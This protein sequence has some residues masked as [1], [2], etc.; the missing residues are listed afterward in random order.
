MLIIHDRVTLNWI[1]VYCKLG[2][3]LGIK[4]INNKISSAFTNHATELNGKLPLP[5]S[6]GLFEHIIQVF[7]LPA[8]FLTIYDTGLATYTSTVLPRGKVDGKEWENARE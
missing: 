1:C 4:R 5:I 7:N 3:N 6:K 2:A 8:T